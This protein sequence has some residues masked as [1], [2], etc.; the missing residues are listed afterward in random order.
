MADLVGSS[1]NLLNRLDRVLE[2]ERPTTEI[3]ETL[4]NLL[5]SEARREYFFK[6]LESPAWLEPLKEDGWLDPDRN[7]MPQESPD[8]P[9]YYYSSRWHA[10]EYVAK[11]STHPECP[12]DTLVNIVNAI[13]DESRERIDNGRTDLDLVKIIG[14]LPIER[15]EPQHITFMGAALKSIQKYGLMDQEIGQTILPKLLDGGKQELTLALSHNN[16]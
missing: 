12:I 10:L 16:A 7:P 1:L 3:R 15:I 2:Y 9:G 8:Q 11:I 13:T 14:T 4:K 5:E 6:K